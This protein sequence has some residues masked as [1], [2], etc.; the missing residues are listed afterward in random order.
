MMRSRLSL[1]ALLAAGLF[2]SA[3][4]LRAQREVSV[5]ALQAQKEACGGFLDQLIAHFAQWDLDHNGELSVSELDAAVSDPQTTGESAAVIVALK[6]A[7]HNKKFTVSALTRENLR[8]LALAAPFADR[9]NLPLMY[10]DARKK[11]EKTRRDLF[12]SGAPKLENIRQGKLGDCFCLAPLGAMLARNPQEVMDRFVRQPDNSYQFVFGTSPV[13]VTVPTDAEMALTAGSEQDGLW[14][15]LYEK[16]V[17]TARLLEKPGM[18]SPGSVIDALG[19]GGSS[20]TILSRLTGHKI[21]RFAC[22][23]AREGSAPGDR[24][25]QLQT[26]RKQL[27]ATIQDHRLITCGTLKTTTPGITPNHAYAVLGYEEKT[28][29]LRLWNPHG[30]DFMPKGTESLEHGYARKGGVFSLPLSDFVMQ[31]SGVAFETSEPTAP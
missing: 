10:V 30:D 13:H 15:S 3:P 27:L 11:I 2:L 9:P 21:T 29:T 12:V 6:R 28:D 26:L 19:K 1:T 8:M 16:A 25:A 22:R 24:E 23:A 17:G 31:F 20:G 14:V 5:P 4:A 7:T 18:T